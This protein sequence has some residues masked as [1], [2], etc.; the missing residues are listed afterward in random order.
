MF[1]PLLIFFLAFVAVDGYLV[2]AVLYHLR[3]YTLPGWNAARVVMPV[4]II[5]SL[6]LLALA[7]YFLFQIYQLQNITA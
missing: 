1:I 7:S 3:Q 6:T 4:F 5:L 2:A